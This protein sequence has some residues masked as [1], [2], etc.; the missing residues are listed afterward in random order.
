MSG[1]S[2]SAIAGAASRFFNFELAAF[3]GRQSATAAEQTAM[4]AGNWLSHAVHI[5]RA[6]SMRM[7]LVRWGAA[8]STGPEISTVSAPASAN[9]AAM[10]YPC[11]PDEWLA[12]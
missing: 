7:S 10:A 4:S 5:W 2:V 3:V 9:A 11:L 8:S 12:M 1:F 6:V